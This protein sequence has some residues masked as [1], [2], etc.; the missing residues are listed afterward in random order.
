MPEQYETT[1]KPMKTKLNKEVRRLLKNPT[2]RKAW[3]RFQLDLRGE[4]FGTLSQL[5]GVKTQTLM[6]VF[7]KSYPRIERII[8]KH[9]GLNP[10][11][12]F[13]ERYAKDSTQKPPK[14]QRIETMF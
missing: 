5:A 12:L 9:F 1:A 3:I 7:I 14:Q 11:D 2:S 10:G 6:T 8:A 4:N 13:P